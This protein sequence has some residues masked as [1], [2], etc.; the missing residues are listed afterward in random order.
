M[1]I[2]FVETLTK[3]PLITSRL[4]DK[5]SR[6]M[7]KDSKCSL[8]N[9]KIHTASQKSGPLFLRLFFFVNIVANFYTAKRCS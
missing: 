4:V 3:S 2:A 9:I 6:F 5:S 7:I 8:A 1:N